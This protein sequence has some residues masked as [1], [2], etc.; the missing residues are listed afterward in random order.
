LHRNDNK[1]L[2]DNRLLAVAHL[3]AVLCDASPT[4]RLLGT[5]MGEA[6]LFILPTQLQLIMPACSQ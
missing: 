1:T 4:M 5:T 3:L 6:C 2:S